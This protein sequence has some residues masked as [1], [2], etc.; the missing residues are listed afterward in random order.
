MTWLVSLTGLE[1]GS[2]LFI[3][4]IHRLSPVV[5]ENLYSAMEDFRFDVVI[6]DGPG[7]RTVDHAGAVRSWRHRAPAC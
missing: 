4:E 5:E 7:A 3:D 2:I 1:H 6:G